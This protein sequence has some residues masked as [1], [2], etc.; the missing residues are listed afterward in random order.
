MLQKGINAAPVKINQPAFS[1]LEIL[2]STAL[3]SCLVLLF[4]SSYTDFYRMQIKQ[5]ELLYL[6]S[7][8]NQ[9]LNYFQ[10]HIQHINF[11][12]LNR[13]ES[14]MGLFLQ[15]GQSLNMNLLSSSCL[16]FFYDLNKDGCIGS[17]R[18]KNSPCKFNDINNTKDTL[19]EIFWFKLESNEIYSF[20]K[21]LEHCSKEECRELLHN[22]D[23]RWSKF[24]SINS[25][26]VN[27]LDFSWKKENQLIQVVLE[28]ESIKDKQVFYKTKSYIFIFNHQNENVD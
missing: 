17:R 12:G 18:T 22:C 6:Q 9:L 20:S 23:G 7:E 15:E 19:K 24:N 26:S 3:A 25:F 21:N 4:S 2:I 27:K 8:A 5:K 13:S 1:L 10:Q 11:Q 14:N 16:I 28:L